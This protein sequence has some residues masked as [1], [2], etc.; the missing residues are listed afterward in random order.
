MK[1]SSLKFGLAMGV[2]LSISFLLCNI[3]FAIVGNGFSL[4][5]M[6]TLFHNMD[7]STLMIENGFS[8]G[9]L[10]CGMIVLFIEGM[11]IGYITASM[12]NLINKKQVK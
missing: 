12:Y 10:I 6:N 9:K 3:F 7:F 1:I 4:S 2:G 8:I 5:I 11:V